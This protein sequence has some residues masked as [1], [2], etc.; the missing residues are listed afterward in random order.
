MWV[1]FISRQKREVEAIEGERDAAVLAAQ[2][3]EDTAAQF[4]RDS[5]FWHGL[6][7]Q[8]G[9]RFGI[10]APTANDGTVYDSVVA[11]KVPELVERLLEERNEVIAKLEQ[12]QNLS[13]KS[14]FTFPGYALAMKKIEEIVR[15]IDG[16]ENG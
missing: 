14:Y 10:E 7:T 16:Q 4:L 12:V 2:N 6:V 11:M 3:W 5:E 8:I 15:S 9:E 13:S 1:T